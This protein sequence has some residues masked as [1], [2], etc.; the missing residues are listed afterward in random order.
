MIEPIKVK[1]SENQILI[2]KTDMM[3]H[4][5]EKIRI[6]AEVAQQIKNGVV[7]IPHGFEY[8]IVQLPK[9][10]KEEIRMINNREIRLLYDPNRNLY[11]VSS[12]LM[13]EIIERLEGK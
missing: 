12:E 4:P 1:I 3:I 13:E 6:R 10:I 2:L 8:E 7:T 9:K 5:K 11:L